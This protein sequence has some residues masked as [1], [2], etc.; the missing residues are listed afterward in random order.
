[1]RYLK[2]VAVVACI[3][4]VAGL[5]PAVAWAQTNPR[6]GTWRLDL[7]R[8][9]YQQGQAPAKRGPTHG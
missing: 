4:V 2:G 7:A 9:T 5:M 6:I 8:S 1:M 3:A